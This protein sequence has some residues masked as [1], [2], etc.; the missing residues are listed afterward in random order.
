MGDFLQMS[1]LFCISWKL[2]PRVIEGSS[3]TSRLLTIGH[4]ISV[5]KFSSPACFQSKVYLNIFYLKIHVK[6]LYDLKSHL[7][8]QGQIGLVA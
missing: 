7:L 8:L 3:S 4:T 6:H 1:G 2:L 5:Q